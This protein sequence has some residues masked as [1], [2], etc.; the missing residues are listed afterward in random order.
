MS[1]LPKITIVTPSFNQGN[2]IRETIE[3]ILS[4]NY[5]NL[6]YFII[7]GGST[8]NTL[9]IIEEYSNQINYWVSEK[10]KGQSDAINKGVSRATGELFAW[11]NSDDILLPNCLQK[12]AECYLQ[13]ER[14]DIIHSNSVYIDSRS[15][16]NKMVRVPKQTLFFANHGV[17]S[18]PQPSVFY[19]TETFKRVGYLNEQYQ[20]SMDLDL[21]MRFVRSKCTICYIPQYLGA[22]RWQEQSKSTLSIQKMGKKYSENPECKIIFNIYL[23]NTNE[24]TRKMWRQI[25]R[26]YQVINMNYLRSYIELVHTKGKSFKEIFLI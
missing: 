23:P 21:W 15:C 10:D 12:I 3:S 1:K 22:F 13:N 18:I 26:C 16:I 6:E 7:D 11:V 20:L 24:F 25:W 17:W 19:K 2:F 9:E 5:D 8:D 14:V 4:Q